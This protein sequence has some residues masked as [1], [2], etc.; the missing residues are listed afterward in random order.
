MRSGIRLRPRRLDPRLMRTGLALLLTA[1]V[2]AQAVA[3]VGTVIRPGPIKADPRKPA[4]VSVSA[5]SKALVAA[6]V[7]PT[8]LEAFKH[9]DK[10]RYLVK[11]KLQADVGG[12][13]GRGPAPG[14]DAGV[15]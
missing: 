1:A 14:G 15:C 13:R 9:S 7:Q 4:A 12:S 11:M 3:M 8:V 2:P 5:D 6:K 10:V